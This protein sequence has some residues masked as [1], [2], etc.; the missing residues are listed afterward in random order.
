M[1]V[2]EVRSIGR[3]FA[4]EHRPARNAARRRLR[5]LAAGV[6]AGFSFGA[7]VIVSAH[8]N[9]GGGVALRKRRRNRGEIAGIHRRRRRAPGSLMEARRRGESLGDQEPLRA[10]GI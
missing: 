5:C 1:Q 6:A 8:Q 7:R 3:Q 10:L 2:V 9:T 4:G